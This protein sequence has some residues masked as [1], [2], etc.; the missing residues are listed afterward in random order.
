M[1]RRIVIPCVAGGV[2][3]FTVW[4]VRTARA[5]GVPAVNALSYSGVVEDA[6]GPVQGPHNIQVTL[7][8]AASSGNATCQ[9]PPTSVTLV[10]GRFTIAL[11]DACAAAVASKSDTWVSVLVDGSDTGRTKIGAVPYALEAGRAAKATAVEANFVTITATVADPNG[12]STD[13]ACPAG[14]RLAT[15]G[16]S[17]VQLTESGINGWA[18]GVYGCSNVAGRLR[19]SVGQYM[20]GT[21]QS[22]FSCTGLCV[23]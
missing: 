1:I 18:N 3:A 13:V 4:A 6:A 12:G 10:N 5:D 23:K 9:T 16:I 8:D 15:F 7:Y 2:L 14:Y 21:S 11:P 17:E 20:N 22:R 19:A